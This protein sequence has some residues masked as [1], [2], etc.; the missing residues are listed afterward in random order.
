M[1]RVGSAWGGGVLSMAAAAI[2]V[3][4]CGAVGAARPPAS[5]AASHVNPSS[6][7]AA[8][9]ASPRQTGIPELL[10]GN[11]AAHA[12][13][14]DDTASGG[15]LEETRDSGARWSRLVRTCGNFYG[16]ADLRFVTAATGF[17]VG[18]THYCPGHVYRTDDAG[19][20]WHPLSLPASWCN[21][22]EI[23]RVI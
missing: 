20:T 11:G 21:A 15:L 9:L 22:P 13:L 1:S 17:A 2:V 7:V 19:R 14:A 8:R 4:G 10:A 3:A 6:R 23:L 16:W 12:F 18:P 5:R